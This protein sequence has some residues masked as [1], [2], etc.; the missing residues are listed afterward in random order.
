[1]RVLD[2]RNDIA[3]A[4]LFFKKADIWSENGFL[5]F[6]QFGEKIKNIDENM[7]MVK[8]VTMGNNL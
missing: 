8:S 1:M 6:S 4:K 5:I 3:Y 7:Q 2:E